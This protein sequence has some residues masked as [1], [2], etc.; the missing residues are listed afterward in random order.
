MSL[1]INKI[2]FIYRKTKKWKTDISKK[3]W[4]KGKFFKMYM[5]IVGK[6]RQFRWCSIFSSTQHG[7][8]SVFNSKGHNHVKHILSKSTIVFGIILHQ[9][10]ANIVHSLYRNR[11][12]RNNVCSHA[13]SIYA[14]L[15]VHTH[16][17]SHRIKTE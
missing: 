1:Y 7:P 9:I 4:S 14:I 12:Y 17:Y 3:N 5:R 16:I 2:F 15:P 13:I 6:N 8:F 10:G 11:L